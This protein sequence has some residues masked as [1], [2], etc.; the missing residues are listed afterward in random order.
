M[1]E[2]ALAVQAIQVMASH[3]DP[4]PLGAIVQHKHISMLVRL[5]LVTRKHILPPQDSK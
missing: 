4:H 1:E 2:V 3:L 5:S